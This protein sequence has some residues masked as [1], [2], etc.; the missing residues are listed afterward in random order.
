MVLAADSRGTFGNP[1]GVTAQNDSM[2]KLY[3]L[4]KHVGVLTA[5]DAGLATQL[6]TNW[7]QANPPDKNAG[8]LSEISSSLYDF[9][10]K[11]YAGWFPSFA[12][13]PIPGNMAPLRPDLVFLLAGYEVDKAGAASGASVYHLMSQIDFAPAKSDF[14]FGVAGV[15][16]YALYLFNRLYRIDTTPVARLAALAAYAITETA[17][18]DGKVGGPLKMATITPNDGYKALS[19][20]EVAAI[21]EANNT[22]REALRK[23]FFGEGDK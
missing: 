3:P 6:I 18:Q 8:G 1:L 11:Q 10:R 5:G 12:I 17:S 4:N 9:V 16:Q 20:T 19:E 2:T 22:R 21:V 23:S 13:Q 15:A 14:G 7:R